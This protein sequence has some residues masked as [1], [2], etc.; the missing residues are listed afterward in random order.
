MICRVV[1]RD[2]LE[3]E[4]QQVETH[5]ES[6]KAFDFWVLETCVFGRVA[7]VVAATCYLAGFRGLAEPQLDVGCPVCGSFKTR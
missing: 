3:Q 4:I 6:Q 5:G 2:R 1:W 7:L